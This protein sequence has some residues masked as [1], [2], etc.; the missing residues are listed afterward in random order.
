METG[1]V[2]FSENSKFLVF[3]CCQFWNNRSKMNEKKTIIF[4]SWLNFLVVLL[5]YREFLRKY[6]FFILTFHAKIMR[7]FGISNL[8]ILQEFSCVEWLKCINFW[9]QITSNS[10]FSWQA[11]MLKFENHLLKI[12][13]KSIERASKSKLRPLFWSNSKWPKK[14]KFFLIFFWYR[15][16][17]KRQK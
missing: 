9:S 12:P 14:K 16:V 10:N 7:L 11:N 17:E 13:S 5:F 2:A 1:N 15:D 6:G 8:T 3:M 4:C